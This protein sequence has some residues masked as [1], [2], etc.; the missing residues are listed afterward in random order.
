MP[1]PNPLSSGNRRQQCTTV[2]RWPVITLHVHPE[3]VPLNLTAKSSL[4]M[5]HNLLDTRRAT[6][7]PSPRSSSA[8]SSRTSFASSTRSATRKCER[9]AD[10]T[11][12]GSS[13]TALVQRA[14]SERTRPSRPR[15]RPG[16]R[17]SSGGSR[18]GRT[19]VRTA[20]GTG[21]SPGNVDA[22][23][24]HRV[25]STTES[26]AFVE[27][28]CGPSRRSA[29]PRSSCSARATSASAVR[30]TSSITMERGSTRASAISCCNGRHHHRTR[31]P[32]FNGAN[33]SVGY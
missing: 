8:A 26:N 20:G 24:P 33:A 30:I 28:L 4:H 5:R 10:T 6:L 16:P 22:Q 2:L 29:F 12:N 15:R 13:A 9:P 21:A 17:P 1:I 27:R 18:S 3:H 7:E 32:R 14:G 11:T 19:R 31:A 25:H 23:P